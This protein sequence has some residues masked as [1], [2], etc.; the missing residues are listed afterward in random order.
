M[1]WAVKC[2]MWRLVHL[3]LKFQKFC[4]LSM[5]ALARNHTNCIIKRAHF[6]DINGM[7]VH[8]LKYALQALICIAPAATHIMPKQTRIN[9][10]T[11][12]AGKKYG[13]Y[14]HGIS[15]SVLAL[16]VPGNSFDATTACDHH[17]CAYFGI[18]IFSGGPFS[19]G[20]GTTYVIKPQMRLV[21]SYPTMKPTPAPTPIPT[22]RPTYGPTP[23]PTTA[24]PT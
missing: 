20:Y 15:R 19:T 18:G 5:E 13:L 7:E 16:Y 12:P 21:Y 14:L 23:S 22:P 2:L 11:I 6:K 10:F 17:L 24:Q 4:S 8:G 1:E 3:I 9:V